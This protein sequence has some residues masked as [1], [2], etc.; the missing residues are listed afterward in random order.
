M[1]SS[2]NM[3]SNPLS[4]GRIILLIAISL[5][6]SEEV[7]SGEPGEKAMAVLKKARAY[8]GDEATLNSIHSLEFNGV[9][10][11]PDGKTGEMKIIL[12]E[13]YQ[14]LQ[15]LTMNGMA[16]E[17]GLDDY[18]AWGKV[19]K[20]D[21]PDDFQYIPYDY[22]KLKA[23]RAKAYENLNFFS[24]KTSA[25][26][27]IEFMGSAMLEDTPVHIIKIIFGSVFYIRYFDADTG[28]LILTETEA[29]EMI[30]ESGEIIVDGV[31]FPAA[32][33]SYVNGEE[34]HKIE[35]NVIKVNPEIEDSV[36][37]EPT[38][39]LRK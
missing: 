2:V 5:I 24:S 1:N 28:K 14:Q 35:F 15:V 37:E 11:T 22:K 6:F 32:L 10:T 3:I 27:K 30:Q 34:V 31:R 17:I 29:G 20:L 8:V 21:N 26:R 12:R 7:Y 16:Q 23:E 18:S 25:S 39:S 19:Y 38:L 9:L 33:T 13:P 36:F 4:F